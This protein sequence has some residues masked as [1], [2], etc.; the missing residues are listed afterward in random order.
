MISTGSAEASAVMDAIA[1]STLLKRRKP[2]DLVFM[3]TGRYC[4]LDFEKIVTQT[5]LSEVLARSSSVFLV[6]ASL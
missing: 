2:M 3:I 4:V 5:C 6:D 1:E